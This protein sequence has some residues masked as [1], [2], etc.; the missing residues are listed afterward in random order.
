M[1]KDVIKKFLADTANHPDTT[2]VKIGDTEV[3]LGSLRALNS[4]D[5]AE[6]ETA[7]KDV[8]TRRTEVEAKTKEV[9]E[10]STRAQSV[11]QSATDLQRQLEDKIKAAGGGGANP[12]DDPWL[13]PVNERLTAREKEIA[14]LKEMLK[15]T[16]GAVSRAAT[17]FADD[18]QE[19]EYSRIDWGKREKKPTRDEILKFATDNKIT[20]RH[21]MPSIAGAWHKMS[22]GDR[23]DQIRL[24]AEAKGRELGRQEALASRMPQ[25]GIPGAGMSGALPKV[26]LNRGDLGDLYAESLKDPEL[27]SMIQ[28]L[29]AGLIQ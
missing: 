28:E 7:M 10:M 9:L 3:P 5:R 6:L 25:P 14:D 1:S 29:P 17:I 23:L 27:R 22:E 13:K 21:G 2:M 26:D 19:M 20:D 12:W 24:E 18:R 16:I 4:D 11:Y 8:N 15:T